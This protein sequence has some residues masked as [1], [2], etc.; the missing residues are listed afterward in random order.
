MRLAQTQVWP[1]LRYFEAIAPLAAIAMSA[2]SKT[3]NGAFAAQFEREL[4][5]RARALLHRQF[6]D[7][8]RASN[9]AEVWFQDRHGLPRPL[10][11]G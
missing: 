6:A 3:M 2:S 5:D 9:T 11:S 8:G 4:L 1:A 10:R 7:L